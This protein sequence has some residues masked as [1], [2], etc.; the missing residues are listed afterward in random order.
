MEI[1]SMKEFYTFP[2]SNILIIIIFFSL[3]EFIFSFNYK[4]DLI[5]KSK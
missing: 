2:E 5:N 1:L 3:S 4:K